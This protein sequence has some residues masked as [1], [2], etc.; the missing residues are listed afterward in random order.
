MQLSVILLATTTQVGS[1]RVSTHVAASGPRVHGAVAVVASSSLSGAV[2]FENEPCRRE[3]AST[4]P[5]PPPSSPGFLHAAAICG[6]PLTTASSPSPS[7]PWPPRSEPRSSSSLRRRRRRP[8]AP[9]GSRS[10]PSRRPAPPSS[11]PSSSTPSTSPRRDYRHRPLELSTIRCYPWCNPG[12]LKLSGLGPSCSPECF[13]Y[14]G[15]MD[16]FS[17]I[18][19][20]EGIFRLWR[21]TAA[22]LALAVPTVGIYLPSYDLLRNWIEEYSD[23]SYPKLR[24][25]APLIA[26]SI[27]RS[28]ACITCSPIELARTRM[29]A[30]KQSSGGAKPPGMWKT[31]L[32]VLSSR[33]SISHP[34]N[35]QT[36]RGYHL[37]WTGMG[38]QLARDV[39]FSA[40][41][42]MVL[43]PTRRHLLGLL[44]GEQSNAAVI[45]GANFSAGFI[46][47]VIS[48][49]ATCPLDVA[50]TRRQIEKDPA[51]VLSMNT[52]RIL[53]EVWRNEGINGLFRGAGPRM[54]RAGPSVGIV[55]SSYEVV[56]HIMH[57]KHAEL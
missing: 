14:R 39:P 1:S 5:P 20:Q 24:P 18:A 13:Q 10:G 12:G 7:S 32:G 34:E 27:A 4:R 21:G 8:S 16:V 44:A 22:S 53:L 11:P 46:A 9:W 47:G 51:R 41:C 45:M 49:G 30:F 57:R 23:H 28:L 29:Q 56:K 25:Y 6:R 17:K 52:R 35:L 54:A 26:G 37:L 2:R 33:Q 50:K 31:M 15:T 3:R 42:W 19:R 43:E 55:V 38:A 48:S 36:T 40:I